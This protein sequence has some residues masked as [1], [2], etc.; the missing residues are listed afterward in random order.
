MHVLSVVDLRRVLRV[1]AP[2][3]Y[4]AKLHA[5]GDLGGMPI[6]SA[7]LAPG[8][9]RDD[10][11]PISRGWISARDTAS[12]FVAAVL[13]SDSLWSGYACALVSADDSLGG[14]TV[15]LLKLVRRSTGEDVEVKARSRLHERKSAN[16]YCN[17]RCKRLFGW[18]PSDRW[19][20]MLALVAA[21]GCSFDDWKVHRRKP[22]L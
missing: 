18:A 15:D 17:E 11:V 5:A 19:E 16:L 2:Q 7:V 1:C 21:G 3:R 20:D 13:T 22:R 9:H 10:G 14:D 12:A 4:M 6:D 8:W